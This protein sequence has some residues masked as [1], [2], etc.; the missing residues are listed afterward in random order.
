MKQI[1]TYY[2]C[3]KAVGTGRHVCPDCADI[4]SQYSTGKKPA[5]K[6]MTYYETLGVE[7]TASAAEIKA[8]WRKKCSENHPDRQ[9]GNA[10]AMAA[11]N[12]AYECLGD[13]DRRASYDETGRDPAAGP[14]LDDVAEQA[15]QI[16]IKQILEDNPQGNLVK[17]LDVHITREVSNIE[18]DVAKNERVI[19]R[20]NKQLDSVVRKSA[21][22]P[23]LF[24]TVLQDQIKRSQSE[25][26][27]ARKHLDISRR[28]L[29]I[30]RDHEDTRPDDAAV[31]KPHPFF[32]D[33]VASMYASMN[34]PRGFGHR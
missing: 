16:L 9:G 14:S 24:N 7:P 34:V 30:L 6:T 25:I 18:K 33:E 23:S 28:A 31:A 17:L 4:N 8:A 3:A 15:L 27:Q 19:S 5:Q 2:C 32:I 1:S 13:P 22:R 11:I 20:L 10:E 29:E 26:E 12:A 21:G